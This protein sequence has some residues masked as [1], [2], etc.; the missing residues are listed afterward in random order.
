VQCHHN[1][2]RTTRIDT[3][4]G[5]ALSTGILIAGA[6]LIGA[7]LLGGGGCAKEKKLSSRPECPSLDAEDYYFA[8][9]AFD[10]SNA[11]MDKISRDWYSKYLQA[12]LEPS[13]SC[14]TGTGEYAYRFL[15]LRIAH[16]PIAVRIESMGNSVT[17]SA[18]E[19][20][21]TGAHDPDQILRRIQ[22]T[23]SP[24]DENKFRKKL[25][26][27]DFWEVRKDQ[28]RFGFEG[29]QWVLE[30]VEN[31]R[32]RVMEKWSPNPG[33]YRDVCF[34]LIQFAGFAIPPLEVY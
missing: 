13:L 1:L 18:V 12:M 28:G 32:Y 27:L 16:H 25:S 34:L 20:D 5:R 8:K 6:I 23:L 3:T 29:A 24:A 30:G 19:L 17:L 31:G 14:G 33:A 10:S 22:R 15:W 26:Q 2:S 11:K 7:L 21:G 9:S 4:A